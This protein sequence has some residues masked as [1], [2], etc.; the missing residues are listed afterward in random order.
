MPTL[1]L[2]VSTSRGGLVLPAL[3]YHEQ[4][5]LSEILKQFFSHAWHFNVL[6]GEVSAETIVYLLV[7]STWLTNMRALNQKLKHVAFSDIRRPNIKTNDQL[8][9]I[10]ELLAQ[11]QTQVSNAKQWMPDSVRAELDPHNLKTGH[12]TF[13]G[14][15]FDE[16]LDGHLSAAHEFHKRL[17]LGDQHPASSLWA[18]AY[19]TGVHFH[20]PLSCDRHIWH[21]Y[22]GDQWITNSYLGRCRDS[23]R[24]SYVYDGCLPPIRPAG[25]KR[26]EG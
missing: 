12:V 16:V 21:E 25:N 14:S 1:H 8:H 22:P 26:I 17:G 15:T 9:D 10:R 13:P 18:K 24:H 11:F 7:A 2:P 20:T 5:S 3:F 6:R 19:P 23:C 4:N